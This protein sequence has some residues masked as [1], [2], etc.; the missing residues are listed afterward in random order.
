MI[1]NVLEAIWQAVAAF[2][3]VVV[4]GIGLKFV[5][6]DHKISGYYLTQ[7]PNGHDKPYCIAADVSWQTDFYVVCADEPERL[8]GLLEYLIH[9]LKTE[10]SVGINQ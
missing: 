3:V 6:D 7:N 4:I 5:V 10:G 8:V 1:D 2:F 9:S